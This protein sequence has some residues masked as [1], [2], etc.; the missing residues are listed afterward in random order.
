M[1]RPLK[2]KHPFF[3]SNCFLWVRLRCMVPCGR[4]KTKTNTPSQMIWRSTFWGWRMEN[5]RY[6]TITPCREGN[7]ETLAQKQQ[8]GKR[9][10]WHH[11]Q[12]AL[13]PKQENSTDQLCKVLPGIHLEKLQSSYLQA[14]HKHM[15][16]EEEE[17]NIHEHLQKMRMVAFY[18]RAIL[19]YK[20]R[21]GMHFKSCLTWSVMLQK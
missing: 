13:P 5:G 3:L 1:F 11:Q 19:V 6:H 14:W 2:C 18:L 15:F 16:C 8:T 7:K 4:D 12:R 20:V 9:K 17:L 21:N 10:Y